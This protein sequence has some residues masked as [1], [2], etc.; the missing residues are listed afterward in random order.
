[1]HIYIYIYG[2]KEIKYMNHII[3]VFILYDAVYD[4]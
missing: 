4:V 3:L 2:G 1:M